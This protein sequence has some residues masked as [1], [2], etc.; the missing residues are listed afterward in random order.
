MIESKHLNVMIKLFWSNLAHMMRRWTLS[1]FKVTGQGNLE[2]SIDAMPFIALVWFALFLWHQQ[3]I[4]QQGSLCPSVLPF[5][6][7]SD[8]MYHVAFADATYLL[9]CP[10]LLD[11][12]SSNLVCKHEQ[13]WCNI[14]QPVLK[15]VFS[16]L[17]RHIYN[18]NIIDCEIERTIKP[19]QKQIFLWCQ[20]SKAPHSDH[21]VRHPSVLS[22]VRLSLVM[23]PHA[24]HETLVRFRMSGEANKKFGDI[25]PFMIYN[26]K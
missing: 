9:W 17:S 26:L 10:T 1:I 21:L 18:W 12:C 6:C 8:R 16:F 11:I 5:V 7:L 14:S 20:Q 4:A 24:L 23:V 25:Y 22:S 13:D 15:I 19:N 2:V 3:R